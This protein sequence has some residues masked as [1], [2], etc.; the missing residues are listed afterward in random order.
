MR[1]EVRRPAKVSVTFDDEAG[2]PLT[3]ADVAFVITDGADTIIDSGAATTAAAATG[4]WTA[5]IPARQQLDHLTVTFTGGGHTLAV[6]AEVVA[7]RLVPLHRL[8]AA[9][10][11]AAPDLYEGKE[12]D[13]V[14]L[15]RAADAAEDWIDDAL[16]YPAVRRP[17]RA[18]F[19]HAGGCFLR[20]RN[21][22]HPGELYE[23]AINGAAIDVADAIVFDRFAWENASGT[24]WP[25]GP[26]TLWGTHGLAQPGEDLRRA[27]TVLARYLA[28]TSKVPERA[29]AMTT[30]STQIIFSRPDHRKPTGL[31][32]VDAVITRR[33]IASPV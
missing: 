13:P 9:M 14:L 22:I 25:V 17:V 20:P 10:R 29:T 23:L 28:R 12:P 16:N 1:I 19:R 27:A 21:V 7:E 3:L 24:A 31:P 26:A 5:E 30:E 32:D 6:H 8:Q 2:K 4:I 33:A 18:R 15:R 11:E